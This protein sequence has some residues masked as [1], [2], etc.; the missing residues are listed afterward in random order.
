[1]E[2]VNNVDITTVVFKVIE[3]SEIDNVTGDDR[4]CFF[5]QPYTHY[6]HA[7][8]NS[9]VIFTQV[10]DGSDV[11]YFSGAP[12]VQTALADDG[13]VW[14][15]RLEFNEMDP[16]GYRAYEVDWVEKSSGGDISGVIGDIE[17]AL[18][19]ILAIQNEL[20]GGES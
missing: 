12:V 7:P 9:A 18:D 3:G 17:T 13:T 16:P 2:R 19:S 10:P 5:K 8:F 11:G 1:M 14:T 4:V 20:I 6:A 15:R